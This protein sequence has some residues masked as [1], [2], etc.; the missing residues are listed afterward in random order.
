MEEKHKSRVIAEW[1]RLVEHKPIHVLDIPDEYKFMDPDLV[2]ELKRAV[3]GPAQFQPSNHQLSSM[4]RC[5]LISRRLRQQL[6]IFSPQP[7]PTH[8]AFLAVMATMAFQ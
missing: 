7:R 8:A 6:E 4:P 2:E 5:N 3:G 1:D